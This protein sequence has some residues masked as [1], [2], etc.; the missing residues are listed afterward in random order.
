M[1]SLHGGGAQR[2]TKA[3]PRL[4]G[5]WQLRGPDGGAGLGSLNASASA[6]AIASASTSASA[7]AFA[8]A[9]ARVRA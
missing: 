9:S 6:S 2:C 1:R 3:P 8:R 4:S 7:R 5:P